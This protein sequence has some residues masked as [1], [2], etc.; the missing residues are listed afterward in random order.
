MLAYFLNIYT[1]FKKIRFNFEV[2]LI[3]RKGGKI[4]DVYGL[5]LSH[6]LS[7]NNGNKYCIDLTLESNSKDLKQLS[8]GR[9]LSVY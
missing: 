2:K 3:V 9:M 4:D 8:Y 1:I 5:S 7:S 6:V